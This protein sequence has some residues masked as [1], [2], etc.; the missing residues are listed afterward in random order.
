MSVTQRAIKEL[1]GSAS[2]CA[3]PACKEKIVVEDRGVVIINAD[4]AHIRSSSRRGPRHD[5]TYPAKQVDE[6]Q[7][8]L[9][10][11]MKHHRL[12]DTSP[13]EPS[14]YTV[15]ELESWKHAQI[16]GGIGGALPDGRVEEI[17][18]FYERFVLRMAS[19]PDF[20]SWRADTTKPWSGS[21]RGGTAGFAKVDDDP[22]SVS[23]AWSVAQ[24]VAG[25]APDAALLPEPASA[26]GATVATFLLD[27]ESSFT[28]RLRQLEQCTQASPFEAM[29]VS[30]AFSVTAVL[31]WESAARRHAGLLRDSWL[32]AGLTIPYVADIVMAARSGDC[33]HDLLPGHPRDQWKVTMNLGQ[34]T[35]MTL[36]L[37]ADFQPHP[38]VSVVQDL[39]IGVQRVPAW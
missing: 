33:D 4:I 3:F 16:A 11:C 1:F 27:A 21:R 32:A 10:L 12:V 22:V 8:L 29:L 19:D 39:L 24:L 20:G 28:A 5:A 35:A 15:P 25:F 14:M 17:I 37:A 2:R 13:G 18:R 23:A 6:A 31:L 38:L 36:Q 7:N 9:L 34:V 30:V 26:F